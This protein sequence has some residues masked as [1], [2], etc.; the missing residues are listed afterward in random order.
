MMAHFSTL[1]QVQWATIQLGAKPSVWFAAIFKVDFPPR[2][3]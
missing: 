1:D 2:N 3:I